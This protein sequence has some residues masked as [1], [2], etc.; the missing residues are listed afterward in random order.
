[1]YSSSFSAEVR[2]K[3]I[4]VNTAQSYILSEMTSGKPTRATPGQDRANGG[5]SAVASVRNEVKGQQLTTIYFNRKWLIPSISMEIVRFPYL[6]SFTIYLQT[7]CAWPWLWPLVRAEIECK[8]VNRKPIHVLLYDD[9]VMFAIPR[10]IHDM[11]TIKMCMTLTGTVEWVKVKRYHN[12]QKIRYDYLYEGNST[13]GH[14]CHHLQDMTICTR[15]IVLLAIFVTIY[16][17]WYN[18]LCTICYHLRDSR[19][20]CAWPWLDL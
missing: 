10:I 15:A 3:F 2:L 5:K 19:K 6:S 17:I 7:R 1:M 13:I 11:F 12:S 18:N 16:K 14:I 9:K 8:Y 4:A 20:R